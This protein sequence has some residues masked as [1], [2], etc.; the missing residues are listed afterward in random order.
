MA[1]YRLILAAV[2][3]FAALACGR[4]DATL[5]TIPF[6]FSTGSTIQAAPFNSNF[7]ALQTCGNNIDNSNIGSAGLYASNL[8]PTTLGQATFGGSQTYLFPNGVYFGGSSYGVN[9]SGNATLNTGSFNGIVQAAPGGGQL[10]PVL[11]TSGGDPSSGSGTIH[12]IAGQ[13]NT[14]SSGHVVVTFT[15]AAVINTLLSA[16]ATVSGGSP[17]DSWVATRSSFTGG[18]GGNV[19]FYVWT[20]AATLAGAGWSINYV[21]IGY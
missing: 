10:P 7:S 16:V 9:S 15:G 21:L 11:S 19:T 14:D 2:F 13:Q 3:G 8:L 12:I 17:P 5:C 1:R 6:T 18:V 20:S 4:A